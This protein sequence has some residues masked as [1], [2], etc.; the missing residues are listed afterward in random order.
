MPLC[1]G[2]CIHD[3]SLV[4]WLRQW[5]ISMLKVTVALLLLL[6]PLLLLLLLCVCVCVCVWS[7]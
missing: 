7:G 2:R 1:V 4:P 3:R 6:L 5:L